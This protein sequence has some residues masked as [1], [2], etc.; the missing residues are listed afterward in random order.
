MMVFLIPDAT[1]STEA[2]DLVTLAFFFVY[3]F[4]G[5]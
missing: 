4:Q 2:A 5:L 3:F 1:I